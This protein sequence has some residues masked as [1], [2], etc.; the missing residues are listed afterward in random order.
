VIAWVNAR[1]GMT[2]GQNQPIANVFD[3][4]QMT[5]NIQVNELEVANVKPGQQVVITSPGLPG[6]TFNGKVASVSAMGSSNGGL[7]TFGVQI[8]VTGTSALKPGMT[9]NAR[10][11]V[12][13]VPNALMVP[14]EAVVQSGSQTEVE[15]LH[16]GE[17][18]FVP[19]R[20]GL[21]NDTS[22]QITS[23]LSAGVVVVTGASSTQLAA[24]AAGSPAPVVTRPPV[25]VPPAPAKAGSG[26]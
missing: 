11:I 25:K 7:A 8:D 24:P 9:A 6:R 17:A 26:G 2:V 1:P 16:A 14:V 13:T 15:V 22:A 23:G 10:I 18:V 21:V 3:A 5:L 19:V 20:V 4:S 12:A